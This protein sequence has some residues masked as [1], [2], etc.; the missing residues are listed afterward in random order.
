MDIIKE[1]LGLEYIH[2]YPIIDTYA[3]TVMIKKLH[4]NNYRLLL[5]LD[6]M[7]SSCIERDYVS[8]QKWKD[9]TPYN[10]MSFLSNNIHLYY[11][12]DDDI[13]VVC[14]T[15]GYQVKLVMSEVFV[16]L[17]EFPEYNCQLF[18]SDVID[19]FMRFN[20]R[21]ALLICNDKKI[22]I[23]KMRKKNEQTG[24]NS[25]NRFIILYL[26]DDYN[27]KSGRINLKKEINDVKSWLRK[28]KKCKWWSIL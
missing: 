13:I 1:N 5:Y 12:D 14:N 24:N 20:K 17:Y 6:S 23:K 25:V 21:S 19:Y 15:I 26:C 16:H 28:I 4:S 27:N 10:S 22:T 2:I 7:N 8:Y 9:K 11:K 18:N 3:C